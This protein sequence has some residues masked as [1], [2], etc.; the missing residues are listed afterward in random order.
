MRGT[1]V[2]DPRPP[3][4]EAA[5]AVSERTAPDEVDGELGEKRLAEATLVTRAQSGD[6]DAFSELVRLYQRRAVAVAYRLLGNVDDARDVSQ[7]A[8]VNAYRNLPQLRDQTRFGAWLMRAV[9][10]LALNHRR[11]RHRRSAASLDDLAVVVACDREPARGLYSDGGAQP[12][13]PE[14]HD[15]VGDAIGRL[16]EKQ[17]L[18]LVLFSVEGMPQK[19]VADILDCSVELVKWNVFQARRKLKE[20]LA[21]FI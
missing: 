13:P 3:T 19:E 16:G 8:F 14:L 4:N 12:L 18:A 6:G 21:E 11:S 9:T 20:M 15:A 17:R 2:T 7:D 10:N 5:G 1:L